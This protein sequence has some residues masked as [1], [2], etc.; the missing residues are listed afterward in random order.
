MYKTQFNLH[1]EAMHVD[2]CRLLLH[3]GFACCVCQAVQVILKHG[4]CSSRLDKVGCCSVC[5][6][7]H[8]KLR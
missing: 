5:K 8:M 3:V 4:L 2:G 6:S 7:A 1:T